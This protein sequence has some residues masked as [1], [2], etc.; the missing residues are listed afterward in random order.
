[1]H[2]TPPNS[3]IYM[4][5]PSAEDGCALYRAVR[6]GNIELVS[7]LLQKSADPNGKP[8]LPPLY[9][10]QNP[11]LLP[12]Q[13]AILTKLLLDAKADVNLKHR[14]GE[15]A[16]EKAL[17][18]GGDK[19][20]PERRSL[21][22]LRAK[23]KSSTLLSLLEVN[24]TVSP[25]SKALVNAQSQ[26]RQW[27]VGEPSQENNDPRVAFRVVGAGIEAY[28]GVYVKESS[29]MGPFY[30]HING[31][32]HVMQRGTY[33]WYLGTKPRGDVMHH[34]QYAA[35]GMGSW[36]KP[37][38]KGWVIIRD[39]IGPAPT[40]EPMGHNC[41]LEIRAANKT[42]PPTPT[43]IPNPAQNFNNDSLAQ[44][45]CH[46]LVS[47][48][49]FRDPQMLAELNAAIFSRNMTFQQ[50]QMV[51][52]SFAD[53]QNRHEYMKKNFIDQIKELQRKETTL[54]ESYL[55]IKIKYEIELAKGAREITRLKSEND[56]LR[57]RVNAL[58]EVPNDAIPVAV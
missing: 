41:V 12:S 25:M 32:P 19:D 27:D 15:T 2:I 28:N 58:E 38:T 36:D 13:S 18:Y 14:C 54:L 11:D 34:G 31:G 50:L 16:L 33:K 35:G 45:R 40:L 10:A 56:N 17:R 46:N 29:G 51:Q 52:A 1:M 23:Q 47:R 30:R 9:E 24:G 48:I 5:R 3:K 55:E 43:S 49:L 37:P 22:L 21:S 20:G 8:G 42:M 26:T 44:D 4:L 6:R 39:G 53:L 57:N 7:N